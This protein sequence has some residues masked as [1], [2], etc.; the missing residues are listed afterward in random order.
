[1]ASPLSRPRSSTG[2]SI[3]SMSMTLAVDVIDEWASADAAMRQRRGRSRPA[4]ARA[5]AA[6]SRAATSALRLPADPPETKQP[7][8]P[9]GSPARSAIQR[10]AWFSA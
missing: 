4:A 6:A 1:M 2:T 8:A 7:P 10:S 5:A 3:T 9:A